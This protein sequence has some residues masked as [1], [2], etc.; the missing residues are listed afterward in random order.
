[1]HVGLCW[2]I[3]QAF[4]RMRGSSAARAGPTC[5][6]QTLGRRARRGRHPWRQRQW[7]TPLVQNVLNVAVLGQNCYGGPQAVVRTC[8]LP[9]RTRA[10]MKIH[11]RRAGRARNEPLS[12]AMNPVKMHQ[13][14][15]NDDDCTRPL[16][17]GVCEA[18]S[19]AQL[20]RQGFGPTRVERPLEQKCAQVGNKSCTVLAAPLC[21][22]RRSHQ[23]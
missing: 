9:L 19:P 15:P 14:R 1:M 4:P 3:F 7:Q 6:R 18:T 8:P 10:R 12:N 16:A 2:R 13:Q 20:S 21:D 23:V 5:L 11:A 17:P 22:G